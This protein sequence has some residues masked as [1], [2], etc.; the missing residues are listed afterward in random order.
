MHKFK[1]KC[2]LFCLLYLKFNPMAEYWNS[3]H[4]VGAQ[5]LKLHPFDRLCNKADKLPVR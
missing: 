4:D 1:H 2:N 3:K 5:V